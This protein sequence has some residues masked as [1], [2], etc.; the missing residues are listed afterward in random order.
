M[1][2]LVA[3]FIY[4]VCA[5]AC[6][7]TQLVVVVVDGINSVRDNEDHTRCANALYIQAIFSCA[8]PRDDRDDAIR[9]TAPFAAQHTIN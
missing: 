3:L 2:P 5:R 8:R 9:A 7:L 6:L 1:R 4:S